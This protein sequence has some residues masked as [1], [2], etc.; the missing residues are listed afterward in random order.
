MATCPGNALSDAAIHTLALALVPGVGPLLQRRLV[1]DLGSAEAAINAPVRRLCQVAGVGSKL[2]ARIAAAGTDQA[3]REWQL[4]RDQGIRVLFPESEEYPYLL[5]EI[6][7][8][9][10][11]LFTRGSLTPADSLSIAVVGTRRASSYGLRNTRRL[12]TALSRAGVTIVSGLARGI[13]AAAHTAALD[14]HGRTVG[15][16][17][18]GVMNVYPP[19]HRQLAERIAGSGAVISEMDSHCRPCPGVFP[20]RNRI[21]TGMCLGVVVIEA[22][23]RSGALISARHAL[24]QGRDVFAL[25]GAADRE[26][27]VGCHALIRDGAT[28]VTQ[29]E[30]VLDAL[31]PLA[32]P[33]QLSHTTT[34]RDARELQLN[35]QETLVLQAISPAGTLVDDVIVA[36]GLPAG[37][38]LATLSVLEARQLVARREGARFARL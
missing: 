5:G 6:P 31:G 7:D 29:P 33:A 18:A 1:E 14:A 36:T 22:S 11:V 37:R 24:E 9:P 25:P 16:L 38:V 3:L 26:Q 15:V 34:V 20:R 19:Q 13:D 27:S 12:T 4:C 30:H 8:P 23:I 10:L 2:A 17:A 35:P 28:L 32:Q 21:V